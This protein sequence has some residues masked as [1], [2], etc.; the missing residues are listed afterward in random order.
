MDKLSSSFK[1]EIFVICVWLAV[2]SASVYFSK[3]EASESYV[4]F[5]ANVGVELAPSW[6]KEDLWIGD[7]PIEF[8]ASY[9]HHIDESWFLTGAY[10]HLS[11]VKQG[12]PFNVERETSLDRVYIG[13]G[14]KFDL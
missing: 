13:F 7:V 2:F 6:R 4:M 12:P 5:E 1:A 14:Y 3:A 9:Y 11:N 8:R 10:S